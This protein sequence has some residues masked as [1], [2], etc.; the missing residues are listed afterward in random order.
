MTAAAYIAKHPLHLTLQPGSVLPDN[1]SWKILEGYIVT[2]Y[3]DEEE[4]TIALG[5][6]G[7]GDWVTTAYSALKPI[8]IQCIS[9]AVVEQFEPTAEDINQLLLQQIKNL[10]E[11]FQLNRIR[12]AD[13]RLITLLAWIGRRF[14]QV[15]TRGYR[16]SLKDMRLTHKTLADICGLTRVTVTKALNRYKVDGILQQV[17]KDDLL[18]P[19]WV[20]SAQ[21]A[22]YDD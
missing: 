7:Q 19:A 9:T 12:A 21:R 8:E 20:R 4:E 6:W 2:N 16:F 13:Q 10:E 5:I 3:W 1:L 14:G 18:I 22:Q 17:S 15:S 11:I